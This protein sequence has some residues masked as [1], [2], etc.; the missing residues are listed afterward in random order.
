MITGSFSNEEI[1]Q[2]IKDEIEDKVVDAQFNAIVFKDMKEIAFTVGLFVN[3]MYIL[4]EDIFE[5]ETTEELELKMMEIAD[6]IYEEYGVEATYNIDYEG[7]KGYKN[8]DNKK[9]S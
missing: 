1:M 5:T 8:I 6:L 4:E 9:V 2:G 7:R 3:D